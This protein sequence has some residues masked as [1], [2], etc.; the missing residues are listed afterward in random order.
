MAR[1]LPSTS[2][3]PVTPKLPA[4]PSGRRPAARMAAGSGRRPTI[5]EFF[6]RRGEGDR[7]ERSATET[8]GLDRAH[9]H[10][11]TRAAR[12]VGR[13]GD[14]PAVPKLADHLLQAGHAA[15]AGGAPHHL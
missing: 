1:A 3:K 8:G 2:R 15:A 5:A 4:S 13:E 6:F 14:V 7:H 11:M 9:L 10:A 12:T